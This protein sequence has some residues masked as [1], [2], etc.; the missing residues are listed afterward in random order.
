M[1]PSP[2]LAAHASA[3]PAASA[4]EHARAH[5]S[6][7]EPRPTVLAVNPGSFLGTKMVSEA[8]GRAGNDV[9]IG[10]DILVACALSD[11]FSGITGKYFDND[12]GGFGPP[13]PDALDPAKCAELVGALDCH[14]GAA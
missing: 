9:G 12:A 11:K 4:R 6:L 1:P 2:G 13:H 8:Y 14:L 5:A 10:A 7:P 3:G